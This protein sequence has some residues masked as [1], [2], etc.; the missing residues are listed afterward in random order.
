M[1]EYVARRVALGLVTL[2]LISI[3][4]FLLSRLVGNPVDLYLDPTATRRD[5]ELLSAS[6]GL[7]RPLY[8]QYLVFIYNAVV[9]S[10][11]GRSIAFNRPVNDVV[12]TR[13]RNT[14]E[15]GAVSFILGLA[16]SIPIGVI[17]AVRRG[18]WADAAIRAFAFL[19]QAFPHFWLGIVLILLVSVKLE[20][21]AP[22]GKEGLASFILP[23]VTLGWAS[24]AGITRLI[25]SSMLDVL[26]T[27]FV[28][29]ARSKGLRETTVV[30]RHALRNALIPAIAYSSVVI[31]RNFVI[32]SIAVETVFGWPGLGRLAYEATL[33]R[34]FPLIQG[35]VIVIAA[36][37]VVVNIGI[38]IVY[39]YA[40]PRIRYE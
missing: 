27:D 6:L 16:I 22:A 11:L 18:T 2:V 33:S 17:A 23:A 13:L 34:D 20:L 30:L 4:V 19:G 15:L 10:D 7:D 36:V 25:R 21:V 31:V 9:R 3:L 37:V 35:I 8:Q 28:R 14:L 29:T 12:F 39:S 32:G 1:K 24:A 26:S 5:R 38:D 40:D